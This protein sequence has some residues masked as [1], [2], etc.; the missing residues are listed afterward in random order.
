MKAR[1]IIGFLIYGLVVGI[2]SVWWAG[3][4]DTIFPLNIPGV[5]LGDETYI[6]AIRYLGDPSS[7]HAH[8]TIPWILRVNQVYVPV[9]IIFWG[10]IGLVIQSIYNGIKRFK[11]SFGAV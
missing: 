11:A 9:S 6:L 4:S 1:I 7:S 10:L 3:I 2:V 8:Y 5:V